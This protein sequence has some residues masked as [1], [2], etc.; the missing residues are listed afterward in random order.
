[1]LFGRVDKIFMEWPDYSYPPDPAKNEPGWGNISDQSEPL[2]KKLLARAIDLFGRRTIN[3]ISIRVTELKSAPR[4]N[5]YDGIA[6]IRVGI[7]VSGNERELEAQIAHEIVHVLSIH[8][9]YSPGRR[10]VLV[11]CGELRARV[12]TE[13]R[14]RDTTTVS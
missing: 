14:R 10:I 12:S 8:S 9:Q 2:A 5:F 1:M 3:L 6:H 4:T 11:F 7:G 13:C